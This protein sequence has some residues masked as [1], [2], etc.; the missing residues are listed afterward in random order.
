MASEVQGL[1]RVEDCTTLLWLLLLEVLKVL[2]VV[3][4]CPP[5][6]ATRAG[7]RVYIEVCAVWR[8]A[9]HA[10]SGKL[11]VL[12]IVDHSVLKILPI[13]HAHS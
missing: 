3:D 6:V 12:Y 5:M 7:Q 13:C 1:T 11:C 10:L 4:R 9:S 8:M 2:V